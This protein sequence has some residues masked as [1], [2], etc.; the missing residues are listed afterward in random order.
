[1]Y[2]LTSTTPC[3]RRIGI[4]IGWIW[5]C[6]LS[7]VYSNDA[8]YAHQYLPSVHVNRIWLWV[9]VWFYRFL[10][11]KS[12]LCIFVKTFSLLCARI[13][14]VFSLHSKKKEVKKEQ[15]VFYSM[16]CSFVSAIKV[17]IRCVLFSLFL[18]SYFSTRVCHFLVALCPKNW[19]SFVFCLYSY[20]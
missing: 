18:L 9:S 5:D 16:D 1:M 2:V 11:I 7:L 3:Y 10:F 13:L 19:L 15:I 17:Y 8:I 14:P 6:S 12:I 4:S 20:Q